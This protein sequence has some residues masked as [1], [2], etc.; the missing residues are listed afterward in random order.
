MLCSYDVLHVA[1]CCYGDAMFFWCTMCYVAMV[2]WLLWCYFAILC[3]MLY[4]AM[5]L[6]YVPV[7]VF[8]LHVMLQRRFMYCALLFFACSVLC[9]S[10]MSVMMCYGALCIILRSKLNHIDRICNAL[11]CYDGMLYVILL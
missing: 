5:V 8:T 4:V 10:M 1:S 3:C 9:Y 11:Y 7:A 2:L 6:L